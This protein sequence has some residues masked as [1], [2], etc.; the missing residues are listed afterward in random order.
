MNTLTLKVTNPDKDQAYE[1]RY[2]I[3]PENKPPQFRAV[4]TIK[5]GTTSELA[6][7][8]PKDS[9]VSLQ[10]RQN[11][12]IIWES[13]AY[14][15]NKDRRDEISIDSSKVKRFDPEEA[16]KQLLESDT[17][18]RELVVAKG[19]RALVNVL[20][21]DFG[22]FVAK[23]KGG[24]WFTVV[25]PAVYGGKKDL[26]WVSTNIGAS[27][28]KIQRTV[29]MN[30]AV[31]ARASAGYAI[32]QAKSGFTDTDL[33]QYGLNIDIVTLM[34]DDTF[35]TAKTRL[36]LKDDPVAK[37]AN[38]KLDEYLKDTNY[39]VAFVRGIHY[40]KDYTTS[41]RKTRKVALDATVT[42]GSF[43]DGGAAYELTDNTTS[44]STY[45]D[46]VGGFFYESD[47]DVI[48]RATK[49]T[50]S[51]DKPDRALLVELVHK[52]LWIP[53]GKVL[54][55]VRDTAARKHRDRAL[56]DYLLAKQPK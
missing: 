50:K 8:F 24:T 37:A 3:K 51:I 17:K 36:A 33:Y 15:L 18:F 55:K 16:A 5:A 11:T 23:K 25:G 21:A 4:Q 54:F 43:L 56:D 40:F 13:P 38:A 20:E 6:E 27:A 44:D 46:T 2:Q 52:P 28:I 14:T 45:K 1:L 7:K 32:F 22:S 53:L 49:S 9:E 35:V 42:A 41:Y 10:A 12:Y 30:R 48:D 34:H 19:Y 31:T 26:N 29:L 47:A 39:V